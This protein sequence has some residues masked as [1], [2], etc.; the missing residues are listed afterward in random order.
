M[1]VSR[2]S[3]AA[4]FWLQHPSLDLLPGLLVTVAGLVAVGRL[5]GVEL[6]MRA[7]VYGGVAAFGGLALA[8]ATFACSMTYQS[9]NILMSRVRNEFA[10]DL[11]VNWQ[12][13][14]I[15]MLVGAVLPLVAALV[16]GL[17]ARL[18]LTLAVGGLAFILIKVVRAMFWLGYTLFMDE[19]DQTLP[20]KIPAPA[21]PSHSGTST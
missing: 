21:R 4:D 10:S 8:A 17:S 18:G 7:V 3:R 5:P 16:D 12:S 13:I 19:V 11:R 9:S 15:W 20:Q 6:E 1:T 2:R 14:I